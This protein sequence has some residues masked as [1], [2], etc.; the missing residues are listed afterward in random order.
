MQEEPNKC[1][2]EIPNIEISPVLDIFYEDD[3]ANLNNYLIKN[4][5]YIIILKEKEILKNKSSSCIDFN[6]KKI[7]KLI[8][9]HNIKLVVRERLNKY[10]E[11]NS[12]I[13]FFDNDIEEFIIY[14][15]YELNN[16]IYFIRFDR[17]NETIFDFRRK[18]YFQICEVLGVQKIE[19]TVKSDDKSEHKISADIS[20]K[21]HSVNGS[22]DHTNANTNDNVLTA[23]YKK[24][25][26]KY[27][28]YEP[29]ELEDE[30]KSP[31]S[32]FLI[33]END[34]NNDYNLR[35][36]I[37]SRLNGNMIECNLEFNTFDSENQDIS[38]GLDI[39]KNIFGVSAKYQNFKS[40]KYT[41]IMKVTFY[42]LETLVST[43]NTRYSKDYSID[44]NKRLFGLLKLKLDYDLSNKPYSNEFYDPFNFI[45]N[46]LQQYINLNYVSNLNLQIS[47]RLLKLL[48]PEKY[49][50][51]ISRIDSFYDIEDCI[52]QLE[53][54]SLNKYLIV[55]TDNSETNNINFDK[56]KDILYHYQN[57]NPHTIL[58][59]HN[60]SKTHQAV[61]FNLIYHQLLV[62][63]I[64]SVM[65]SIDSNYNIKNK[66]DDLFNI[67]A[68]SFTYEIFEKKIKKL[69]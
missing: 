19:Y 2:I 26:T 56:I 3:L 7:L 52:K 39:I 16:I 18:S 54:I 68:N 55:K 50:E 44:K 36:L 4:I 22:N 23:S 42:P 29:N 65:F 17:Y 5:D 14:R 31:Q 64:S 40:K 51:L 24:M 67:I 9:K 37:R 15:K 35:C 62:T 27:I 28:S 43:D 25:F 38:I 58:N 57:T 48:S 61:N 60:V 46:Y 41:L 47:L 32:Y 6:S 10:L 1:S 30:I 20:V 69:N 13:V 21:G 53:N 59:P 34:F 49:K 63:Y 11:S 33:N 45:E 8:N 66:I 12:D